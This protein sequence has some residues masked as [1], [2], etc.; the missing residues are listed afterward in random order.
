MSIL[1]TTAAFS[2]NPTDL[3]G[4]SQPE[5]FKDTVRGRGGGG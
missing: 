2:L 4:L 5:M 1:Q 3:T